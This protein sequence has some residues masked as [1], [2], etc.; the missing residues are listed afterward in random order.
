MSTLKFSR[1][2]HARGRPARPKKSAVPPFLVF[3]H[4]E[5]TDVTHATVTQLG[6]PFRMLLCGP[7][8]CGKRNLTLNV[9]ANI[10]P[11]PERLVVIHMDPGSNEYDGVATEIHGPGSDFSFESLAKC[12]EGS[13]SDDKPAA[14]RTLVVIDEVDIAALRPSERKAMTDLMRYG[15]SHRSTSVIV[16][17]QLFSKCALEIRRLM[18]AV[19][20]WP[21]L[22]AR[23]YKIVAQQYALDPGELSELMSLCGAREPLTIDLASRG[24][25]LEFRLCWFW[26]VTR[27]VKPVA[28]A[29]AQTKIGA[30]IVTIKPP[31]DV[32]KPAQDEQLPG[33]DSQDHGDGLAAE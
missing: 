4:P 8:S 17:F 32:A 28:P 18:S 19:T 25:P 9:V 20:L 30:G 23:E 11:K 24:T 13:G 6:W 2:R 27:K 21:G 22:D 10:V 26:P 12:D 14:S 1:S 5:K 29:S 15:S 33:L 3:E 7:V 16:S 31:A